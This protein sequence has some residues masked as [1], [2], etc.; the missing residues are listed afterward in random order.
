[1]TTEKPFYM[2]HSWFVGF[3][4]ADKPEVVV[5]V[6]LGNPESWH[7]RGH[8]AAK[9]MIDRATRRAGDREERDEKPRD[10]PRARPSKRHR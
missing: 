1:M 6:L 9:R 5:S 7:L 2:E 8:E 3:A 10:K 4:P